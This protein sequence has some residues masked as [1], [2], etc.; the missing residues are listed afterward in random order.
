MDDVPSAEVAAALSEENARLRRRLDREARIRRK[1][2]EIAEDGLRELYQKQRELE[3]LS[4]ITIMAN[5]GGSPHEVLRPALEYMCRFTGWS[6]AHAYIVAG[7]GSTQRMWPSNIW[8]CA[9]EL[10]LAELP[11]RHGRAC[12]RQR[13]KDCSGRVW[14]SAA[15]V[16]VEDLLTS[17]TFPRRRGRAG[18]RSAR[19]VQRAAADRARRGGRTGVLRC[20]PDAGGSDADAG[21]PAGGRPTGSGHRARPCQR[22]AARFACTTR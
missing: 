5:L 20:A 18:R 9:P 7:E 6:A 1:A 13:T 15:P 3:F 2:E 17:E 8:H 11:S 14:A 16:W 10:D 22:P 19:R 12:F 21:D 4:Q